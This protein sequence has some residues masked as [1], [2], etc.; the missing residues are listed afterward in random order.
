MNA[1]MKVFFD[2]DCL[3]HNPPHEFLSGKQVSYYEAPIRILQIKEALETSPLLFQFAQTDLDI[4]VK[5]YALDVHTSDYLAYLEHAY[6]EWIRDG[7]DKVFTYTYRDRKR[8]ELRNI[9][10]TDTEWCLSR[11]VSTP[12]S[13]CSV[14]RAGKTRPNR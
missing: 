12:K 2:T 8:P 10:A 4:D 3:L 9:D 6:T 1:Q 14:R 11:D 5:K 13:C 7:N